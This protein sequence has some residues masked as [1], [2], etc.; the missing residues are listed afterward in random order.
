MPSEAVMIPLMVAPGCRA[1][2]W[3]AGAP[4]ATSTVTGADGCDPGPEA[5]AVRAPAGRPLM[6]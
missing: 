5:T 3:A 6:V 4:V 1:K 2:S